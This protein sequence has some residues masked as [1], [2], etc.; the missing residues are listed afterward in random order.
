MVSC[1]RYVFTGRFLPHSPIEDYT[2]SISAIGTPA[3]GGT[4]SLTCTV[5]GVSGSPA[6]Q[7]F[8]PGGSEI[9]TGVST[10]TLT[11]TITF[12]DLALSDAGEYTCRSTITGVEREVVENVM[13]QPSRFN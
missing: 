9:A 5:E 4:Y 3:L 6:I 10:T 8:G 1:Y 11:S 12:T 13:L 7:W 2:I